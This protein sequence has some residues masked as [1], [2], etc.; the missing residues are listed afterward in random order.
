MGETFCDTLLIGDI[1]T[2]AIR[3]IRTWGSA[4]IYGLEVSR[5][6]GAS[7]QAPIDPN[8]CQVKYTWGGQQET[9]PVQHGS[10]EDSQRTIDLGEKEFITGVQGF[11]T[12]DYISRLTF[13]TNDGL[14]TLFLFSLSTNQK[15]YTR[16]HLGRSL[17]VGAAACDTIGEYFEWGD[18]STER[19]TQEPGMRLLAFSGRM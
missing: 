18:C 4:S 13:V 7:F 8:L 14:F 5:S 12:G 16:C 9:T 15:T 2:A 10:R 6:P 11:S 17:P 1:A 19:G 3:R